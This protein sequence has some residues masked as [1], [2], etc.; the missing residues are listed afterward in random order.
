[1][2]LLAPLEERERQVLLWR[3]ELNENGNGVT[4][5]EIAER[6]NISR[7]HV[8]RIEVRT[9]WKLR[10]PQWRRQVEFYEKGY[11]FE[12][13]TD[14]RG[15]DLGYA[16]LLNKKLQCANLRGAWLHGADL[17]GAD[18]LFAG[19]RDT[20]MRG[21]DLTGATLNSSR[22]ITLDVVGDSSYDFWGHQ[23][24]ETILTGATM[25]DGSIHD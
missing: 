4:L 12:P 6:L 20:D 7:E 17:R 22:L 8:R 23:L 16:E 3:N 14:L 15:A 1:M 13:H 21:A 2:R 25:P 19:L 24:D 18:L 9:L 11:K 5:G 10:D